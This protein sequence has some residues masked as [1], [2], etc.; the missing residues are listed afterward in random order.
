MSIWWRKPKKAGMEKYFMDRPMTEE[1][2][3]FNKELMEKINKP[4]TNVIPFKMDPKGPDG[5]DW[6]SPMKT[7]TEF[8]VRYKMTTERWL[9]HEFTHGGKI[10]GNVLICPT[11]TLNDPR[12]WKWA[13]PIEFCKAFELRGILEVPDEPNLLE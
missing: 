3:N 2:M 9:L 7:G 13:D 8:L 11:P 6:L 10:H 1:E 5:G 4:S 12:T